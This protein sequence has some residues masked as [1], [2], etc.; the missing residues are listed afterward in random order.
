VEDRTDLS[1]MLAT[2]QTVLSRRGRQWT[3][4]DTEL[5][6]AVYEETAATRRQVIRESEQPRRRRV[7]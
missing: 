2:A 5:F 3:D 7:V 1:L 4:I 6:F